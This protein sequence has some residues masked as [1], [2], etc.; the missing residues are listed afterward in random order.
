MVM[1]LI[2][3]DSETNKILNI[4]KAKYGLKDKGQAIQLIVKKFQDKDDNS[5]SKLRYLDDG[6]KWML[7]EDIP[8]IDLFFSQVFS[9]CFTNEFEYPSGLAYKKLLAIFKGYNL[10]FYFGEQDSN[11]V[12]ENIVKKFLDEPEFAKKVNEEIIRYADI[13]R[14]YSEELPERNIETY[15]NQ[16]LWKMYEGYDKNHTEYYQWCWIPVAADMFHNNLTNKLKEYLRSLKI[17]EEK[18]NEYFITLTTPTKK[19]LIEIERIEF[20]EIASLIKKDSYHKKLFEEL[21]KKFREQ[22]VSRFGYKTHTKEYEELLEQKVSK[23]IAHIKPDFLKKIKSHYDKYFYVNHMWVGKVSTFEY[24]L[25]EL[26]KLIDERADPDATLKANDQEFKETIETRN[27]LIKR[28]GISKNYLT[29]FDAF[30]DFMVTKIYRRYSQIYA[31]YKME[32][33]LNEI[34]RRFNLTLMNLRFMIK[35]EVRKALLEGIVDKEEIQKRTEFCTYYTEKEKEIV[36]TGQKAQDLAESAKKIEF[37]NVMELKGQTGCLGYGKGIVKKIFRPSDMEKMNKG[38]V[39]VSIATDP[40]IVPAMK[41]AAAIVTEQ[42]GVTSHAAIVSRELKIPC[43]IGTKIA[44]KVLNDGDLV[45]VD[46]NKG[47]VKILKKA[48]K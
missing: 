4:V 43:V 12:A 21:Y 45:E 36:F 37:M 30:G 22:E 33:I 6:D 38:D 17:A 26:V 13:L 2:E 9:S 7:A 31:V 46:A 3:L 14:E 42:G 27:Q 10:L 24:Y 48:R 47:I 44:T 16:D 40:D 1:A 25:K 8:D 29:L 15:S 34:A 23:L 19:S 35:D 32:F 20:L 18:V 5:S 41:K 39:L 28:L 11:E